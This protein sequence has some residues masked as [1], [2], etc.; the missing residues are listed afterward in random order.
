M[1]TDDAR[2]MWQRS[3]FDYS[4]LTTPNVEMLAGLL[5]V[6][7]SDFAKHGGMEMVV[8]Y[9]EIWR[10]KSMKVTSCRI[11]VDGPY[12]KDRMGIAFDRDGFIGFAGWASS[13]NIRPFVQ[14]F[15]T[16]VDW[17]KEVENDI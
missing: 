13:N 5:S 10:D 7:L 12:F 6:E 16:W 17:L 3:G 9:K 15:V 8:A 4:V 2:E 14:A 11:T 1:N